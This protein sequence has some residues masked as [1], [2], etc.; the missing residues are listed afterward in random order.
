MAY[1]RY[2]SLKIK[3]SKTL[4]S[5]KYSILHDK[6]K[7]NELSNYI[8]AI[9]SGL[10]N[11]FKKDSRYFYKLI[12]TNKKYKIYVRGQYIGNIVMNLNKYLKSDIDLKKIDPEQIKSTIRGYIETFI[13]DIKANPET[14]TVKYVESI[15]DLYLNL[16]DS[17]FTDQLTLKYEKTDGKISLYG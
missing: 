7:D 8:S 3:I 12:T 9:E 5:V 10:I 13:S 1:D 15:L 14:S 2:M 17:V 16:T 11:L 6:V 4:K